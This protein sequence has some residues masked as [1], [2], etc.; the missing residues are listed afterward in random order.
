MATTPRGLPYPASTDTPDVPADI[1]ALAEAMEDVFDTQ[2][3]CSVQNNTTQS[4]ATATWTVA[5]FDTDNSD[6]YAMHST[7]SNT[8]RIIAPAAGLYIV[9]AVFAFANNAT[10][11]RKAQL[12][13]NSAGSS[14]GGTSLGHTGGAPQSGLQFFGSISAIVQLAASDYVEM[15]V[16]QDCG[17]SLN[18]VASTATNT[19]HGMILA[20][21]A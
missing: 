7:S 10:G 16:Y 21:F 5:T 20:R 15:F 14:T 2:P 18:T 1:Q 13:K 6:A 17:S 8:S 12:R 3:Y 11:T 19:F 4:I 9:T